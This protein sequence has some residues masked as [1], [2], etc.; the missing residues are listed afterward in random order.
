MPVVPAPASRPVTP[1]RP[2]GWPARSPI[3]VTVERTDRH[4]I[5]TVFAVAGLVA[6]GLMAAYGLPP[7]ELHGPL[8]HLGIMGPTCGGTRSVRFA[9]MG[10][11]GTSLRYNPLGVPLVLGAAFL[12]VRTGVGAVTRRWLN[13]RIRWTRSLVI[14]A[15]LAFLALWINQ[16][17]H[18]DLI[19][20]AHPLLLGG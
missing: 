20:P 6:A 17:L 7:V 3:T 19:G 8:H 15:V 13:V 2:R 9:M 1:A 10:D 11:F 4:R 14:I 16:Q 5:L 18:V 12:V